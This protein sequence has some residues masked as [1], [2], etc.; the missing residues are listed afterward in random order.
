ML[1]ETQ[2]GCTPVIKDEITDVKI[3]SARSYNGAVCSPG[4]IWYVYSFT[5][6]GEKHATAIQITTDWAE[7]NSVEAYIKKTY[8]FS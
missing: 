2:T 7:A 3:D 1:Q 6:N 8:I 4:H 5:K